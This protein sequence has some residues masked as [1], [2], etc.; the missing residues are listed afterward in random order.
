MEKY[1]ALM[2]YCL[3]KASFIVFETSVCNKKNY[4]PLSVYH[5]LIERNLTN[6]I[7]KLIY[8]SLLN[9]N[10]NGYIFIYAK[11]SSYTSRNGI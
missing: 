2:R 11:S 8:S 9:V 3:I 5:A 7:Y 1:H 6:N 10:L 4:Y